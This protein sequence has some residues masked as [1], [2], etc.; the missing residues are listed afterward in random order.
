[1]AC[2]REMLVVME[3]TF[4]DRFVTLMAT[5]RVANNLN[6]VM[7]ILVVFG[8]FS[9]LGTIFFLKADVKV[10]TTLPKSINDRM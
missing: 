4:Y 2:W 5:A 6:K 8:H 10:N 1:M 3:V 9:V 7:L